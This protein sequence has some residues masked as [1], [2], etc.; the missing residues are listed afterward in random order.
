MAFVPATR[1]AGP[2]RLALALA[3]ALALTL[4]GATA[5]A[6]KGDQK[7][8]SGADESDA[9]VRVVNTPGSGAWAPCKD[10]GD[11]T[12]LRL[13][14]THAPVTARIPQVSASGSSD[15]TTSKGT[16]QTSTATASPC[17]ARSKPCPRKSARS[18][19]K[20]KVWRALLGALVLWYALGLLVGVLLFI[21]RQQQRRDD[22]HDDGNDA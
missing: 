22:D 18:C 20:R 17:P 9:A 15:S 7:K 6:C 4:A 10:Q 21:R 2:L 13:C 3:A 11:G 1:A 14:P 12:R 16:A 8:T 19:G 5:W